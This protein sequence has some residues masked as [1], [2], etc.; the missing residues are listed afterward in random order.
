VRNECGVKES[1]ID[2]YEN[3]VLRWFGHVER[4]GDCKAGVEWECGRSERKR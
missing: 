3:S 2:K 1:I 4:M